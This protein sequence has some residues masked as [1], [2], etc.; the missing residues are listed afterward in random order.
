MAEPLKH[1]FGPEVVEYIAT[2]IGAVDADF[3][4]AA[5]TAACLATATRIS[6]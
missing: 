2:L 5:F 3:D 4:A 6:S 1:S